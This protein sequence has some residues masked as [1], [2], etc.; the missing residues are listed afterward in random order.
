MSSWSNDNLFFFYFNFNNTFLGTLQKWLLE[1][2]MKNFPKCFLIEGGD[3][4]K[5]P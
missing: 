3:F 5:E 1:F 2:L 4:H